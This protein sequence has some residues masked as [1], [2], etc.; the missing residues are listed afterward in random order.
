MGKSQLSVIVVF[1]FV[2][3]NLLSHVSYGIG[4]THWKFQSDFNLFVNVFDVGR[5]PALQETDELCIFSLL[6]LKKIMVVYEITLLSL[7][8]SAPLTSTIL[9]AGILEPH[10]S[11]WF[12]LLGNGL[13]IIFLRRL[14]CRPCRVEGK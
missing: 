4:S 7:C 1:I 3:A 8:L 12:S 11:R 6:I 2:I 14:L 9:K 10:L 5:T 13:V